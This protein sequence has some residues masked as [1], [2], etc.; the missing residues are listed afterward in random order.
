MLCFTD[1]KGQE[2]SWVVPVADKPVL[3]WVSVMAAGNSRCHIG[4]RNEMSH[5]WYSLKMY[6]FL[7]L[8]WL[9]L[10]EQPSGTSASLL[11]MEP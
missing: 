7:L 6:M 5:Q 9:W 4:E 10:R 1:N 3:L 8:E 11:Q 2:G